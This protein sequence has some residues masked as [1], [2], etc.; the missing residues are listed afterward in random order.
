MPTYTEHLK[1]ILC[2]V[3]SSYEILCAIQ[4]KPEDLDL[5]KLE[6]L[7]INGFLRVVVNN[8]KEEKIQVSGFRPLK[9]KIT[10]Y[11]ENYY[12]DQEIDT[13]SQIYATDTLRIKN[14]RLMILDAL[15]DKKM[16]KDIME[17][18]NEI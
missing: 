14:I 7:K 2:N 18:T 4:D 8:I 6:L 16:V 17:L 9:K 13:I 15:E 1:S 12:F 3:L 10:H 11:L 5:I